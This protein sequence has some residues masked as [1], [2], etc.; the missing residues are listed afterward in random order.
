MS[1]AYNGT[2][3]SS[4]LAEAAIPLP[5]SSI[6]DINPEVIKRN[7]T[8]KYTFYDVC[9]D[10]SDILLFYLHAYSASSRKGT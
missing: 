7:S 6:S 4:Y 8:N 10:S 9:S 5:K 3:S 1:F 2:D